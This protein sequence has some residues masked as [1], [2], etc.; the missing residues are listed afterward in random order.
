MR[1][2]L[3]LILLLTLTTACQ[4]SRVSME[5]ID[6]VLY[7]TNSDES[8]GLGGSMLEMDY[9]CVDNASNL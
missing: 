6:G 8:R 7:V 4:G 9:M 1:R 3:A 5:E 2:S